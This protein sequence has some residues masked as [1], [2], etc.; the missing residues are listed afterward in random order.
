MVI[1]N[2]ALF[3]EL[4]RQL[5]PQVDHQISLIV[6]EADRALGIA[7][8]CRECQETLLEFLP[9]N[10][11]RCDP[12]QIRYEGHYDEARGLRYVENRLNI[13]NNHK[14][15]AASG[16]RRPSENVEFREGMTG[17]WVE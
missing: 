8:E 11:E 2:P 16:A 1:Q 12:E 3:P 6:D 15:G 14:D 7:L 10:S 13:R 5:R 4:A 17:R 9:Q